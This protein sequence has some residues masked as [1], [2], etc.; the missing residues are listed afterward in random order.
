MH[1]LPGEVVDAVAL[2]RERRYLETERLAEAAR[3]DGAR[4]SGVD[5]RLGVES[6]LVRLDAHVDRRSLHTSEA[7]TADAQ[8]LL[9]AVR[10]DVEARQD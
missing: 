4:R 8:R 6:Q 9:L 3:K 1:G 5:E 7:A 2:G 10:E